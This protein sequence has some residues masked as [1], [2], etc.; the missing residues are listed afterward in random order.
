MKHIGINTY[1]VMLRNSGDTLKIFPYGRSGG[2]VCDYRVELHNPV[3]GSFFLI[4]P[5]EKMYQLFEDTQ[6]NNKGV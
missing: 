5:K 4:V 6:T 1:K 2:T 3:Y